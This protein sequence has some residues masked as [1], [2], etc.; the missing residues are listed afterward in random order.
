MFDLLVTL[1]APLEMLVINL[2][3]IDRCS[4]RKYSPLRTYATMGV[5]IAILIP[6]AYFIILSTPNFGDGSG[7]FIFLGFFFAIPIRLLYKNSVAKIIALACTSW[8]YTFFLFSI[9][10]HISYMIDAIPQP[11]TVSVI[12]TSLYIVSFA[13]FYKKLKYQLFP[14]FSQL[15]AKETKT[16][17]WLGIVWFWT[18]FIINLSFIYVQYQILRVL[19]IA[20]FAVCAYNFYAYIQRLVNSYREVESLEQIA[21]YDSLTQLYTR[22]LLTSD[23][24]QLIQRDIRFSLIFMDLNNFKSVNDTY[25]HNV[26]D[27]YLAFFA[28]E[29]KKIVG[30]K[31]GFYRIA[32]DEFVGILIETSTDSVLRQLDQ[33]PK[34]IGHTEVPFLG[35][36]YG[37]AVFPDEA[38][39][40]P[41]LLEI[42]DKKMYRMKSHATE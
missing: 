38:K 19:A 21:Y 30:N 23:V 22:A 14:M 3:V 12:Q 31:G 7:L 13:W 28:Q 25:G 27:E 8:V 41:A 15:N 29:T 40:L 34:T 35:V 24:E 2:F 36:S 39:T 11:Y 18:A 10:V 32:G 20:S 6:I 26:G 16:L 1:V 33:L 4:E 17:M 42:A 5:F 37:V 9:S